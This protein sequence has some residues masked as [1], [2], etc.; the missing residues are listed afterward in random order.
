MNCS[1]SIYEV[2]QFTT[3]STMHIIMQDDDYH[4]IG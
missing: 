1:T 3:R 4:H 2:L